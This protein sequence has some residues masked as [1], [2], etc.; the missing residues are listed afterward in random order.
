[1]STD[2]TGKPLAEHVADL[3]EKHGFDVTEPPPQGSD[4]AM[5]FWHVPTNN[6][7]VSPVCECPCCGEPLGPDADAARAEEEAIE[8]E[9][10]W[11]ECPGMEDG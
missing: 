4:W 6:L 7:A 5:I 3:I 1:M 2:D 8:R 9:Y 10:P 11:P